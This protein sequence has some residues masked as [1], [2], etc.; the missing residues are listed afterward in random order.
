MT[1]EQ[2][3]ALREKV[4][5]LV[6]AHPEELQELF[7]SCDSTVLDSA[8]KIRKEYAQKVTPDRQLHIGI[9]GR[10]KAGK[11]SLLNSLLFDGK[12][13]LPKAATPMTAALTK[14]YY[15]DKLTVKINFFEQSDIDELK[16]KSADYER[17]YRDE[18]DRI[19]KKQVELAEKKRQTVSVSE[20]RAKCANLA[21]SSLKNSH[22]LLQG[23]YDLCQKYQAAPS[24]VKNLVGTYCEIVTDDALEIG[25]KLK[26]YVGANGKYTSITNNVEIGYPNETLREI[27]VV[28]TPGFDDP[29]PS[30]DTLAREALKVCDAI[31]V[32]SP[33]S[34][35]C[36][37][38]D[39]R[40]ISKI[41]QGEGIQ[42]V[43][44]V[45]SRIDED[46]S[47]ESFNNSPDDIKAELSDIVQ[48]IRGTMLGMIE[49]MK[50]D[51]FASVELLDR[52]AQKCSTDMLYTSALCQAVYEKWDFRN[53]LD[54]EL[55][56]L[57]DR[58]MTSYAHVIGGMDET[59]KE[60]F[61]TIGN[62]DVIKSKI[63]EVKAKKDEILNKREQD[64]L[65]AKFNGVKAIM[66]TIAK[67]V[68][69]QKT[70]VERADLSTLENE[71]KSLDTMLCNLESDFKDGFDEC[72]NEFIDNVKS[73]LKGY[74]DGL[75]SE[76]K[77]EV[78]NSK[79]TGNK[80]ISV[81]Y[82]E[83]VP[84]T[85]KKSGLFSLLGRFLGIGGYTTEWVKEKRTRTEQIVVNTINCYQVSSSISSF[86][87]EVV[88]CLEDNSEKLVGAFKRTLMKK[89]LDV[90]KQYT[91]MEYIDKGIRDKHATVIVKKMP[92]VEF[93]ID[94][95]IPSGFKCSGKLEEDEAIE[96]SDKAKDIIYSLRQVCFDQ[97]SDYC[98]KIRTT[99]VPEDMSKF[100]L[101][102][103]RKH[104]SDMEEKVKNKK[105]TLYK[106]QRVTDEVLSLKNEIE[107]L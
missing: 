15:S 68:D 7:Q 48:N 37:D 12:D 26:E 75:Y 72:I 20:L 49:N 45:A 98:R 67:G 63:A 73:R 65:E 59:A 99:F 23:I 47:N 101:E 32:L 21:T 93:H 43:Y 60:F 38:E 74:I 41:Q 104:L 34:N 61:K 86:A 100:V 95:E 14:L 11:S 46:L 91:V 17:I 31:F 50:A 90:W 85:V 28:D 42:E 103:M 3:I 94:W 54:E 4:Q 106:L 92:K 29:I 6:D 88:E 97:I 33:S 39:R 56:G 25:E 105:E 2:I 87:K 96:Y 79:G 84:K 80:S 102:S 53:S 22:L 8:E 35:F 55:N 69:C 40:N 82:E 13:V 71:R 83:S 64:F 24:D 16:K 77:S 81:E 51:D 76:K 18:V 5:N 58:L 19:Y 70:D 44:V 30:R 89:M 62:M 107:K 57:I 10:V 1:I 36:N 27:T 66:D 9:V 52:M 78:D